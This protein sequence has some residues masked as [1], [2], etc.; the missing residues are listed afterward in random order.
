MGQELGCSIMAASPQ[1]DISSLPNASKKSIDFLDSSFF[2]IHGSAACLPT[3]TEVRALSDPGGYKAQPP[4]VKF[5]RLDLLVKYGPHVSTSEAQCLWMVRRTFGGRIPVPEV[6][7]W[8]RDGQE[9]FI[10][11]QLVRGLTLKDR[12]DSLPLS[13]RMSICRDLKSMLTALR[14]AKPRSDNPFIGNIPFSVYHHVH[15]LIIS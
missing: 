8:R 15:E 9:V 11:M 7:G 3:P 10:Y 6:Y 4:P 12:W 13:D 2:R 14:S 5:E 1:I